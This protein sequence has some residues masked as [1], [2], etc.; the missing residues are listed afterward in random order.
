M[1]RRILILA[2]TAAALAACGRK[3]RPIAPEG[4]TYPRQY[5]D[6]TFPDG[7]DAGKAK[8][9]TETP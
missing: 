6:I 8:P 5:P 1:K 3:S 2:L 9:R 4:A 7:D